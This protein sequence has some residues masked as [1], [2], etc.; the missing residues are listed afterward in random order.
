MTLL[1]IWFSGQIIMG[2]K[3]FRAKV[4]PGQSRHGAKVLLGLFFGLK[5]ASDQSMHGA[6]VSMEPKWSWGQTWC[7]PIYI[8]HI[9]SI[10]RFNI[11]DFLFL[12]WNRCQ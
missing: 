2:P 4:I 7:E 11:S 12:P 6:K 9:N 8:D 1:K 5:W 3:L 10:G